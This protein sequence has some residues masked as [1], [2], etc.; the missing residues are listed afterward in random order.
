MTAV[1]FIRSSTKNSERHTDGKQITL[2]VTETCLLTN[3][4]NSSL[5]EL[6]SGMMGPVVIPV[7]RRGKVD[8]RKRHVPEN[9]KGRL[10]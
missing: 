10:Q 9:S 5:G 4:S 1:S 6:I 3:C 8:L 7:L 2:T